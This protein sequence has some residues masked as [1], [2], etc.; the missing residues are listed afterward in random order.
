VR[1]D[2]L[3]RLLPVPEAIRIEAD[4][5]V[6]TMAAALAEV[7]ILPEAL[8]HYRIMGASISPNWVR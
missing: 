4:E 1:A 2:V 6:F 5:F 8:F 7:Y 3:R